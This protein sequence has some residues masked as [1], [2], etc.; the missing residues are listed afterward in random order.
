M[1]TLSISKR[2]E[3]L[4][5]ACGSTHQAWLRVVCASP[6]LGQSVGNIRVGFISIGTQQ[7]KNTCTSIWGCINLIHRFDGS[8]NKIKLNKCDLNSVKLIA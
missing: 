6:L 4:R 5:G 7:S 2:N 8:A 3:G 1:S